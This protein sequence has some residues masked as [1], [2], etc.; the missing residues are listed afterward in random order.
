M[1]PPAQL[2]FPVS[3]FAGTVTSSRTSFEI[4]NK[5]DRRMSSTGGETRR[6]LASLGLPERDPGELPASPGRFP[7]GERF[8]V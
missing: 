3:P 7:D 6:Y 5:E 1:R 2:G 4:P 8:R